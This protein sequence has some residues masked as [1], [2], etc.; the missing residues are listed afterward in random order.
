MR[1]HGDHEPDPLEHMDY[2]AI[3]IEP[4]SSVIGYSSTGQQIWTAHRHSEMYAI[5]ASDGDM[6]HLVDQGLTYIRS[7]GRWKRLEWKRLVTTP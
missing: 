2:H 3:E 6:C 4:A 5:T 1:I 7:Q